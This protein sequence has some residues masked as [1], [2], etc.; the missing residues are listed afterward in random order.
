MGIG[1]LPP[2]VVHILGPQG[3]WR[4]GIRVRQ[5]PKI[6][7]SCGRVDCT[8]Q[9]EGCR[10]R[11]V[12][13]R[14]ERLE[15]TAPGCNLGERSHRLPGDGDPSGPVQHP[16]QSCLEVNHVAEIVRGGVLMI[17]AETGHPAHRLH[18][19]GDGTLGHRALFGAHEREA[20]DWGTLRHSRELNS[21]LRP[22]MI[23]TGQCAD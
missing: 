10:C 16:C 12:E 21:K 13:G 11:L 22:D 8:T 4:T 2:R 15:D 20:E 7:L 19:S 9:R 1:V 23:P 14:Q 18:R 17:D 3:P 5:G 6:G